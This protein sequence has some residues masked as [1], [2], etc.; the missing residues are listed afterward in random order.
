[1]KFSVRFD[2]VRHI[3]FHLFRRCFYKNVPF[4]IIFNPTQF[5]HHQLEIKVTLGG[6]LL[7]LYLKHT[8][9]LEGNTSLKWGLRRREKK[10]LRH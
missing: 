9:F 6:R 5:F 8:F 4:L 3:F 10:N 2:Q 7:P 1:M